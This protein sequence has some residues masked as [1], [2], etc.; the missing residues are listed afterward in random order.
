MNILPINVILGNV[1][2]VLAS[3]VPVVDVIDDGM[4][5][6]INHFH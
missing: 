3:E 6:V 2:R 4:R 1:N 5:G